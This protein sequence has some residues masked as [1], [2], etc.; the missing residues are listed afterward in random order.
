[1]LEQVQRKIEILNGRP[2]LA[3]LFVL[4]TINQLSH[5]ETIRALLLLMHRSL[6]FANRISK[7]LLLADQ[8]HMRANI[9]PVHFVN[10]TFRVVQ[11][12][13]LYVEQGRDHLAYR[14]FDSPDQWI[15]RIQR[16]FGEHK[17]VTTD[18]LQNKDTVTTIYQRYAGPRSLIGRLFPDQKYA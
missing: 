8:Y 5:P 3:R 6:L 17:N 9:S 12:I 7:F 1:M 13:Q 2:P 18:I 4:L 15:D 16:V 10:L 11:Y 14:Y